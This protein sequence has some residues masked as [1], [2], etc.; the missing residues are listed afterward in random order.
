MN[1]LYEWKDEEKHQEQMRK[2]MEGK[3]LTNIKDLVKYHEE[4]GTL[5]NKDEKRGENAGKHL[6]VSETFTGEKKKQNHNRKA[7]K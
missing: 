1:K 5:P 3:D 6:P 4:I 7:I 2:A